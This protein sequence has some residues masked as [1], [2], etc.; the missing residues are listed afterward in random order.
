MAKMNHDKC[1]GLLVVLTPLFS[2]SSFSDSSFSTSSLFSASSLCLHL[3]PHHLLAL[4][5]L[6]PPCRSSPTERRAKT[7]HDILLCTGS[8]SSSSQPSISPLLR[9][10]IS[11][12]MQ[13]VVLH[14]SSWAFLH[15]HCTPESLDDLH[16]SG[17]LGM[18]IRAMEELFCGFKP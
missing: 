8:V 6:S 5:L 15:R 16:R 4:R 14:S 3:V 11:S 17:G 13:V 2:A 7:N 1:H 9:L 18:V 12:P 10:W